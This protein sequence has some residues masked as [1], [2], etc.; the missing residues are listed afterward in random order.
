M[1]K[2][3]KMREGAGLGAHGSKPQREIWAAEIWPMA[4]GDDQAAAERAA[5]KAKCV[6]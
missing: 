5:S 1:C 6:E 2:D 4:D 3:P